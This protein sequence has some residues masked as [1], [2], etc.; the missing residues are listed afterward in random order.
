MDPVTDLDNPIAPVPPIGQ[1]KTAW[2]SWILRVAAVPVAGLI[3]SR[4]PAINPLRWWRKRVAFHNETREMIYASE[5]R[6]LA[7]MRSCQM[8]EETK[9]DKFKGHTV[10]SEIFGA[11]MGEMNLRI[12]EIQE[13]VNKVESNLNNLCIHLIPQPQDNKKS[14]T[15]GGKL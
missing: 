8:N 2:W 11:K 12:S 1:G 3:I 15:L 7:L 10:S 5:E 13:S 9:F 6:C 14:D 4:I